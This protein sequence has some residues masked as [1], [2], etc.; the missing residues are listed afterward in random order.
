MIIMIKHIRGQKLRNKNKALNR[1]NNE[2]YICQSPDNLEVH[3]IHARRS[4]GLDNI[5]NL[6]T[7]C[8]GC[9]KSV[10]SGIVENAVY[11]CVKRTLNLKN[12]HKNISNNILVKC[13][14]CT[15]SFNKSIKSN[16]RFCSSIC[17]EKHNAIQQKIEL[18]EFREWRDFYLRKDLDGRM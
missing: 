3:H 10:E 2:C 17:R 11:K 14:I 13:P 15:T 9:H 5:G 8:R 18:K 4:G 6:I 12:R 16:R 7:L 1:D